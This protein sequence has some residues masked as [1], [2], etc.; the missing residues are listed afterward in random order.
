[1]KY[2]WNTA[3]DANKA[4]KELIKEEKIN[5]NFRPLILIKYEAKT[6]PIAVPTTVKAVGNVA[7]YLI[8]IMPEAIIPLKKTV[9]GAT[10][11]EKI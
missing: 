7:I 5:P 10:V 3:N 9:T 2:S 8:S 4:A 6:L 1:M 11:N